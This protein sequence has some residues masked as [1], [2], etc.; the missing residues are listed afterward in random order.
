M[1]V[2]MMT[3]EEVRKTLNLLAADLGRAAYKRR[4]PQ[5]PDDRALELGVRN[6]QHFLNEAVDVLA[7]MAAVEAQTNESLA[8]Y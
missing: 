2:K 4:H 5:T 6:R 3:R 1:N 8:P 7:L